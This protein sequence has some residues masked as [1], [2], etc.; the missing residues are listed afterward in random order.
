MEEKEEDTTMA[1]EFEH[2]EAINRQIIN[3]IMEEDE[4]NVHQKNIP[5]VQGWNLGDFEKH[6]A[7]A[8]QSENGQKEFDN[9]WVLE[10]VSPIRTPWPED[11]LLKPD[12]FT[13]DQQK[14]L[15]CHKD[16]GYAMPMNRV[17]KSKYLFCEAHRGSGVGKCWGCLKYQTA[18]TCH[19]VYRPG[20]SAYQGPSS[21][22]TIMCH[23]CMEDMKKG[24]P[25]VEE[26]QKMYKEFAELRRKNEREEFPLL[27]QAQRQDDGYISR[28]RA[29]PEN[30][31]VEPP[32]DPYLNRASGA[33]R[34][35]Q[36]SE[37]DRTE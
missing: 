13:I 23:T 27:E 33:K 37:V 29:V 11:S 25:S 16:L 6:E 15:S 3:E 10:P 14:C 24:E 18:N 19:I 7:E 31:E 9:G 22:H 32:Y 21:I 36:K 30:A 2:I 4:L 20:N 8:A 1:E 26:T 5:M 12:H 17:P 34:K 35:R 28:T